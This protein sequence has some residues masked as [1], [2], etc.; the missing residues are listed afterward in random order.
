MKILS[1]ERWNFMKKI[2]AKDSFLKT[3][4]IDISGSTSFL[5]DVVKCQQKCY[6]WIIWVSW[7]II[8]M[9]ICTYV[10]FTL[11]KKHFILNCISCIYKTLYSAIRKN[12]PLMTFSTIIIDLSWFSSIWHKKGWL[13]KNGSKASLWTSPLPVLPLEQQF[14]TLMH[15]RISWGRYT[16]IWRER[17][18]ERK[19]CRPNLKRFWLK[20]SRLVPGISKNTHFSLSKRERFS[21]FFSFFDSF[22]LSF[23]SFYSFFKPKVTIYLKYFYFVIETKLQENN[24]VTLE[25]VTTLKMTEK[26]YRLDWCFLI[27][28]D[29]QIHFATIGN[30][31]GIWSVLT[32]DESHFSLRSIDCYSLRLF[33]IVHVCLQRLICCKSASLVYPRLEY[34]WQEGI[35]EPSLQ[36]FTWGLIGWRRWEEAWTISL[37]YV[38]LFRHICNQVVERGWR[39]LRGNNSLWRSYLAIGSEKKRGVVLP[40]W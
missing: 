10:H 29:F 23:V 28:L 8:I 36:V 13:F 27:S 16:Y 34:T 7:V 15:N 9:H 12:F 31:P 2:P 3:S 6:F 38:Q 18:G 19:M 22:L 30:Y 17:E 39:F 24:T 11:L 14:E 33:S 1:K 32:T 4:P 35:G 37:I 26:S 21:P 40:A 25:D 20:L 5:L